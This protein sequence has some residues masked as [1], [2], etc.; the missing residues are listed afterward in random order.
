MSRRSLRL[1]LA[2]TAEWHHRWTSFPAEPTVDGIAA[3]V[4]GRSAGPP[5][6]PA[7]VSKELLTMQK[8]MQRLQADRDKMQHELRT[9]RS[10]SA[11]S[12]GRGDGDRRAQGRFLPNP[13]S[14]RQRKLAD[15]KAKG[16]G[17]GKWR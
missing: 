16:K 15:Q 6:L 5:D 10:T 17:K 14:K 12:D 3:G 1:V 13:D 8:A 11:G 2:A 4:M 9:V 7:D